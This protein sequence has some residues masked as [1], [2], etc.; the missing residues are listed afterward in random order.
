[1][2]RERAIALFLCTMNYKIV[3]DAMGGDVEA[4]GLS[5]S[6]RAEKSNDL[7]VANLEGDVVYCVFLAVFLYKIFYF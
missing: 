1:M 5:S 7:A 4:G 2:I 3:V 6:V